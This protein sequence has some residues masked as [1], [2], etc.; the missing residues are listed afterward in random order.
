MIYEYL[1]AIWTATAPAMGNHLWQSTLFLVIAGLL[2]LTLRK[3]QARARYGLW[4]AASVKFLIPFSLLVTLGSHLAMP[5]VLPAAEP[6]LFLTVGQVSQPFTQPTAQMA[7]H[8][9]HPGTFARLAHLV[10]GILLVG[11][12]SG[13]LAVLGFWWVRWRRASK[14]IRGALHLHEGREVQMLRRLERVA[15]VRRPIDIFLFRSSLEPGIV[16]C[17]SPVLIL[18]DGLTK[19]LDDAHLEAILAHEVWHVRRRDNLAAAV[20]M[21]VEALFWFHPLVWWVGGR[22]V[23]ERERACDEKVL[24]WYS[25]RQVYA[26]SILKTCEF[27]VESPVACVSGVTGSDLK[28]RIVRIM[29]EHTQQKL[30]IRKKLLLGGV[31][32]VVVAVPFVFGV[33]NGPQTHAQ[34]TQATSAPAPSF[35]V[36]SLKPN[37]GCEKIPRRGVFSPSPGRLQMPCVNLK[38]LIQTAYGTFGD[39]V[40]INPQ[41]LHMEGGPSWMHSEYYSLSAKAD[42]P[43]RTEMLAGPMLQV[44]LEERFRL[45]THREMREIPVY[46]MIV[47]NRSLKVQPLA[48]GACTP[49]DLAHPPGPTKPG[50]PLPNVCDIMI[51]RPTGTGEVMI[52]VRGATMTQF[53]QR[54]SQF[55]DRTVIDKTGI[56]GRF[57][58]HL[59]FA[60]DPHMPGQVFPGARRGDVGNTAN[61]SNPLPPT[62]PG[63]NLF[64]AVQG[65][66]G[67]ELSSDKGLVSFLTID[68]VEKPT[69]N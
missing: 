34:S 23:D 32:L 29:T 68:H 9:D 26:E 66:I 30:G 6:G 25:E 40:T 62:N 53:A 59:E 57:N 16:G 5:R 17:T 63:P 64:A 14:G 21:V 11:W 33:V 36:V 3:N 43:A 24:E 44:L 65:Q 31:G 54:L 55:V 12:L 51:I 48:E 7:S 13:F 56:A 61:T 52:D 35:K 58:F 8:P 60:P 37:P 20:H 42:A 2:T 45:K 50:G 27:C 19:R 1:V 38:S 47:G 41:P 4:L 49:I 22:L 67:L 15:G 39:G 28:K 69:A 46:A 18:P 10:P